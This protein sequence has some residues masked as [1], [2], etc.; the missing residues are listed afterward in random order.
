[1]GIDPPTWRLF[2]HGEDVDGWSTERVTWRLVMTVARE[3]FEV[4]SGVS[5]V[6]IPRL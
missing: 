5:E 1:V 3:D 2:D 6:E 4:K